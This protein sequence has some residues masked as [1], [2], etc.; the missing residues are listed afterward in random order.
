M[1]ISRI[2]GSGWF[3]RE[4]LTSEQTTQLDI[5][6]SKGI[7]GT[8]GGTYAPTTPITVTGSGLDGY[9]SNLK[10]QDDEWTYI[11][12]SG[13]PEPIEKVTTLSILDVLPLS[14]SSY[15]RYPTRVELKSDNGTYFLSLPRFPAGG[16]L[17]EF[18]ALIKPGIAQASNGNR[19]SLALY[20]LQG[21]DFDTPTAA[22]ASR[23]NGTSDYDDGSTDL[24][25]VELS[26]LDDHEFTGEPLYLVVGSG[27]GA[28]GVADNIYGFEITWKD[29]GPRNY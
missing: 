7:D 29:P 11:D 14:T 5:N 13:D 27:N 18:K 12:A 9:F 25:T 24:Q 28:S 22:T 19:I 15:T 6:A 26:E 3:P 1:T 23:I 10:V 16:T 20:E 2:K 17:S 21:I 8:D 4:R